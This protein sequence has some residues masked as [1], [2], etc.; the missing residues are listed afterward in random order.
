MAWI[1]ALDRGNHSLKVAIFDSSTIIGRWREPI[2]HPEQTLDRIALESV[3]TA[4]HFQKSRLKDKDRRLL[5]RVVADSVAFHS[6][7]FCSVDPRWTKEIERVLG[8]MGA[9]RI[10]EV[11][12]KI[13][14]PF[15]M[16]VQMPGRV[17]PDRLAA[18]AGVVACGD[19]EGIIVDAGTAIT[20]DVLSQRGFL[21]GAIFPGKD[22]MYRALHEGTAAL[23]LVTDAGRAIE[24]PGPNTKAA[25]IT[26]VQWGTVGAVKELVERSRRRVS[27]KAGIWVTGG[28]G[29]AIASHLGRGTRYEPDLV[30]LGLHHLFEFNLDCK[31]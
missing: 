27:K 5:L 25:I 24:P 31:R 30:F 11:S 16:L 8:K 1:L 23:P 14:L 9:S 21:G 18:A 7:V 15:E 12:S 22:L 10:L 19:R 28:G 3:L 2:A 6:V 26:G 13:E 17:G 20:V 4:M 29:A